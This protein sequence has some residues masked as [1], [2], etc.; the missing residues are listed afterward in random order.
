MYNYHFINQNS[1]I[2]ACPYPL[3]QQLHI[4]THCHTP[5]EFINTHL[6]PCTFWKSLLRTCFFKTGSCF[7]S[8][9]QSVMTL[10]LFYIRGG[11][12]IAKYEQRPE[13][14]IPKREITRDKAELKRQTLITSFRTIRCPSFFS[15]SLLLPLRLLFSTESTK[16][17]F[18]LSKEARGTETVV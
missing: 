18:H 3:I 6:H 1:T 2:L 4:V 12:W 15:S 10:G 14:T 9:T 17:P 13:S 8:L 7:N 11:W 5:L 16:P